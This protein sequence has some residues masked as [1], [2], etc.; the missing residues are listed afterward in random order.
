MRALMFLVFV[1]AHLLLA[2][3]VSAA[4]DAAPPLSVLFLGDGGHHRPADRARQLIPVMAD[5]GIKIDYTEQVADLNRNKLA[6][7]D[8]LVVY[9]NIERIEPEQEAALLDYVNGGGGF[10]PIH[11][12]SFCFLN[13]PRYIALV[14]AQ[15]ERH[16]TGDFTTNVADPDH[17]ITRG[18]EPFE[19]WDETYVHRQHNSEGRTV[20]Q[21]RSEAGREEPWTWVRQQGRGRVFYT[22]YGHDGQTWGNPGFQALIER[23][24]RW[25]AAKGDVFDSTPH[26]PTTGVKP[27]EFTTAK[28]PNYLP[29]KEWGKQGEPVG[30]M[31]LPLD[32]AESLKHLQLPRGFEARLFAAEPDITKPIAMA[33]DHRGRLWIAETLDYPNEIKPAGQGRDRIKICEDTDGDGR[34]DKFTV[35][36]EGLSIPTSL[37]LAGGGLVVHQAP[38]TLLL[39]DTDGD[40]RADRRRVLLNGWDAGDTHAGPSNLRWGFDN[41]LYSMDGYSGF[42]GEVGGEKIQFRTGFFRFRPDG[43]QLEFLRNTDNNSWGV[44]F[45]EDGLLFGSTANGDPS[46]Y[47]PIPNRYYEAVRGWSGSVLP[48]TAVN[49]RMYPITKNVRQV[50]WHG[51][52]TAAAGSALYTARAYP[53][54]YWNRTAFVCEPTG[55]LV[56]TF[57]LE[58]HGSD[59]LSCNSWNLAASDDQ[60]TAPIA[61][62]VG[63]DGQVWLIDWYNY[64]V[65]H[66]P[67][68]QGFKT[69]KGNA[70][71]TDLRDKRHGRIY[72]LVYGGKN[73]YQPPKLDPADP[74]RLVDALRSDNQFWRLTAQRLLVERGKQDVVEQLC[75]L[76]DD[77]SIDALGLNP[78]AL[79]AIWTLD[80]LGV[81]NAPV[82]RPLIYRAAMHPAAAVRRA[83]AMVLKGTNDTPLP[84]PPELVRDADPHVRLAALLAL[85]DAPANPFAAQQIVAAADDPAN[86]SDRW[87]ADALACAAARNDVEFLRRVAARRETRPLDAKLAE[88]AGRVA[89]HCGRRA[90]PAAPARLVTALAA[91]NSPLTPAIL[92]GLARGWPK[93][94][95]AEFDADGEQALARLF[96]GL[97]PKG[98]VSWPVWPRFGAPRDLSNMRPRLPTRCWRL[99]AMRSS[100]TTPGSPR[101]GSWSSSAGRRPTCPACCWNRLLREHRRRWPAASLPRCPAVSRRAPRRA[102]SLA[103]AA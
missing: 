73:D 35:F 99:S 65:Q 53:D 17:P 51:K 44:G 101:P 14:G 7:Y 95:R 10:V 58:R 93:N 61:A 41:W 98:K 21:T 50:D 46:V 8:A 3:L 64:I 48:R 97:A 26:G 80:G 31:Q 75:R 87:I 16:G 49:A 103:S 69:G 84:I 28:L 54:W 37:T 77:R 89:E 25:A 68:P 18:L 71:E 81:A 79:H 86:L 4:A 5:R 55:H 1:T 2:P 78:G 22:A 23:G 102:S 62:E 56:A 45:S 70:Y 6:R 13:S 12:A 57:L 29:G 32:P 92:A 27:F 30:Q 47:L 19:T 74:Q 67:T 82:V 36:A 100:Q 33:W 59:F 83:A 9:A 91:G 85:A 38:Q 60:W 11:C 88:I 72:R 94:Q 42:S 43:S 52:F 90:A 24:I 96:T 39:F 63:P 66:N 15:F 20:L 40:D 76:L 34:A